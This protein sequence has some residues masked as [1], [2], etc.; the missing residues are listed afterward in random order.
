MPPAYP[1]VHGLRR[2]AGLELPVADGQSAGDRIV[3][4]GAGIGMTLKG[5]GIAGPIFSLLLLA[6]AVFLLH[7]SLA[8]LRWADLWH[9]LG[10]MPRESIAI[11]IGLT[12]LSH[13]ALSIHDYIGVRYIRRRIAYPRVLLAAFTAYSISHS[14]GFPAV[15]GG[16]VRY[17]MYSR[18]NLSA[19]EIAQIMA[20]AGIC[21]FLGMFEIGGLAL[22]LDGHRVQDWSDLP[23]A[24]INALGVLFLGI[25]AFYFAIGFFR[26]EPLQ[27]WG[28]R[29]VIPSPR[30]AAVQIAISGFDWLLVAAVLYVLLPPNPVFTFPTFLGVFVLA[31]LLATLSNVPGG[32][33]VFESIIVVSLHHTVP[34]EAIV[35]SLLVYRAVYHLLPL[36]IGGTLFLI[37]EVRR[38]RNADRD[39]DLGAA[40]HVVSHKR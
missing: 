39:S 33:G 24:G 3:W 14:L 2:A 38:Q 18:W 16:T 22:L 19:I 21:M 27:L 36:T 5:R 32:L 25:V 37:L 40:H 1:A 12:A 6:G 26:T 8:D 11:A 9:A 30:F 35:S 10:E 23:S 31:Y 13:V 7:R 28:F 15:T 34:T 29:L 17:R 4:E 20:M